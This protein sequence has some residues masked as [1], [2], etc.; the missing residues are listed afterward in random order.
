MVKR[1]LGLGWLAAATTLRTAGQRLTGRGWPAG[2]RRE[3]CAST[4]QAS[5]PQSRLSVL[6][7][8]PYS[9]HPTIHGGAVRIFNLVRR[10]ADNAEVSVLVFCGGTDDPPQRAAL[11]PFC[12]RVFFQRFPEPDPALDPWG[13]LP[14]SATRY[15]APEVA[16]RI[17]AIVEA[18]RV[19]VVMLEYTEMGQF[20][21]PYPG[22]RTVLVEHD[23]SFRSHARQRSVGIHEREGAGEILGRGHGDWLRRYHFELTACGRVDQIHVMSTTDR[24]LLSGRIAD[25]GRRIHVIPNG[26]DTGHFA[27]PQDPAHRSGALFVGSFP[28]LPNQDAFEHLVGDIWPLVRRRLPEAR[29]TVAGARPPRWVLDADGCDGIEVAGEVPDLAPLYRSHRVLLAPIRAGSGTR[30]KILEAMSCGLPVVSTT[31][32]AEGIEG[33]PGEHLMVADDA[34]GFADAAVELLGDAGENRRM[35]L[36]GAGRELVADRYDWD[37]IAQKLR[38]A[39][40]EIAPRARRDDVAS[41]SVVIERPPV[42]TVLIPVAVGGSQI[43]RCLEA[44]SRQRL[45]GEFEVV[46]VCQRTCEADRA[47]IARLGAH[48]IAP[49]DGEPGPVRAVNTGARAAR[50][51]VLVILAEDAVPADEEWLARLVEPFGAAE[52]P[53]AVQGGLHTQFVAGGPPYDPCFTAES[54]GW[55]ELMGGFAFSFANAAIRRDVWERFP[56]PPSPAGLANL[57]W[58][59]ELVASGELILPCWAAAVHWIRPLRLPGAARTAWRE[60]RSWRDLGV[61][62]RLPEMLGDLRRGMAPTGTDSGEAAAAAADAI[63]RD[64]RIYGLI[65]P[66]CLFLGN[67][68]R[69]AS[70]GYNAAGAAQTR[71]S[72]GLSAPELTE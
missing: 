51:R 43:E 65:R 62:Y 66:A 2:P 4:G 40:T 47:L 72:H 14:P 61:R 45:A 15:A 20:A 46:C 12:R 8:S 5:T 60:G 10:L 36:A 56:P 67:R 1:S 71:E 13:R 33:R 69:L 29:L 68:L 50:G 35:A 39:L 41:P 21:G 17:A 16:D 55:R 3:A 6:V 59:R 38:T 52:P 64:H 18:H 7:V 23:L 31:I 70:P 63:T 26:V 25:G 57:R 49:G 11:E 53:A 42:A 48:S 44:V 28:H 54:R 24:D 27:P 19:D 9:I 34:A 22:A 32:G 30:L 37:R 58:Q